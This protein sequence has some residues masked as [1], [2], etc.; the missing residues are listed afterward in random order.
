M[1]NIMR[2]AL[3]LAIAGC[4]SAPTSQT[5]DASHL[6]SY[7]LFAVENRALPEIIDNGTQ[8]GLEILGGQLVLKADRTFKMRI[9]A[10]TQ[11]ST[12][13][14]IPFSRNIAGTF[15]SSTVGV[16]LTLQDGGINDGA[17]FGKTLSV[18]RDGVQ[19]LFIRDDIR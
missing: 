7:R 9:D 13:R 2:A 5:G 17:F 18:Y 1:R 16:T 12:A 4:A 8:A 15:Q 14:P 10:Q 3:V 6:G 11:M 19:F